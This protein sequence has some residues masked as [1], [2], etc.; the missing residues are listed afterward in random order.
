MGA[1]RVI[2]WLKVRWNFARP[3]AWRPANIAVDGVWEGCMRRQ[4]R[5]TAW[6]ISLFACLAA[7]S[8]QAGDLIW[9]VENPFRFFKATPLFRIARGRVQRGA[10]RPIG[11]VAGRHHL[12]HRTRAQRSRLQGCLDARPLRGDRRQALSAKPARLGGAD[13]GRDLLREQRP[14]PSLLGAFASANIPGATAKED[15]V[16]PEAHTVAIRIA[17]EQLAGV[18]GDCIWT[19]QPRR[20]GGKTETKRIRLHGQ[21]HHR[22]R[23]LCARSCAIPASRSRSSCR[24]V[25]S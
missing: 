16:L 6:A 7:T 19:W 11:A 22:A 3:R 13:L 2:L 24:T 1:K 10:R 25:A 4:A 5:S 14:S 23:A 15:Y 17:P 12:A 21:A 18:S 20:A 8:S 9:E